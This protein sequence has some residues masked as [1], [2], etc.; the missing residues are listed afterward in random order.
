MLQSIKKSTNI[1]LK[2]VLTFNAAFLYNAQKKCKFFKLTA[3]EN[4]QSQFI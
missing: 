2:K 4:I 1:L 3:R